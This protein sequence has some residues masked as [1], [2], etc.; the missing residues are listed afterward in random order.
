MMETTLQPGWASHPGASEP[1]ESGMTSGSMTDLG[2]LSMLDLFREEVEIHLPVLNEGLLALEKEPNQPKRLEALMRAAHSIKGAA[3]IVGVE[4]AG[5][6]AHV[7]EDCL[8]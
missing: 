4:A 7:M 2:D 8:V 6:L 3:R 5:Q 1:E